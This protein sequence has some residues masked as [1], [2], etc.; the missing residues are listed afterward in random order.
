MSYAKLVL[1]SIVAVAQW[2]AGSSGKRS[3]RRLQMATCAAGSVPHLTVPAKEV[4]VSQY[5]RTMLYGPSVRLAGD[6]RVLTSHLS[7]SAK[8]V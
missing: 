8:L 5:Q 2:Q 1:V 3:R 4:T 7:E 6:S